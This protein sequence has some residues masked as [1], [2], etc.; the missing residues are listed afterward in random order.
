MKRGVVIV[1]GGSG[2]RME[3][4]VPKQYL[5]LKGKPVI[6]HTL[7]RFLQFDPNISIVVVLAPGHLE[8]WEKI[9]RAYGF[10]TG[11]KVTQGGQSRFDSV[12][13]GLK[14]MEDGVL[15]GIH[16]AVRPLVNRD[17]LQ[18]C[19]DTAAKSGSAIPVI[20]MEE[21]IR[22]VTDDGRS[23][24]MDRSKLKRVQTPQVFNLEMI[25]TAYQ[26]ASEKEYTDDASVF[27]SL[28]GEV[29]LV[30]GNRENIKITTPTDLE[31]ASLLIG[32]LQ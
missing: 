10:N 18:R 26:Q 23:V 17:T 9:A 20:D 24:H 2:S 15:V 6:V 11:I 12:A 25:R 5:E 19:Y 27:E 13:N 7:D 3:S 8:H 22:M 29:T 21:T 14:H 31:L 28:Y 30:E 1:A 32:S 4:S 16:D